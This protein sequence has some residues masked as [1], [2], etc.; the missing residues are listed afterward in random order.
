MKKIFT[1][2]M[3]IAAAAGITAAAEDV[4]VNINTDNIYVGG[5]VGVWRNIT[6]HSTQATIMP[7]IGYNVNETFSVGTTLGWEHN[8][9]A[10]KVDYNMFE[11]AP[12]LRYNFAKLGK[13]SIFCDGS[14]EVGLGRTSYAGEHSD[15]AAT[16]GIGLK[17]GVALNIN[18]HFSLVAH[19]G[20]IGYDGANKAA[21]NGGA[22]SGWGAFLNGNNIS[23]GAYYT[24]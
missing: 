15:L 10:Q 21:R 23:F 4:N 12:Y 17:P 20:F 19:V 5:S 6:G 18:K 7:E 1:F 22:E 11:I 3:V 14:V 16:Y 8:H 2:L 24:F 9:S 13:V